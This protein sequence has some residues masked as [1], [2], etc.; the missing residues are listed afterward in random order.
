MSNFDFDLFVI[1][2]GSGGVRAARKAAGEGV[3]V[4]IAEEKE[5]GGTCV[6][7]GCVPKKLMVYAA[8][9]PQQVKNAQGFGWNASVGEFDWA[10]FIQ[11]K[12]TEILRLNGIYE[13]LLDNTGVTLFKAKA[14]LI[15][16][17]TLQVGDKIIT[18]KRILI[19]VGGKPFVP[20]FNGKELCITSD[21]VFFLQ[22]QPKQILVVG[23][24]YIAV[25]FA[26]IFKGMGSKVD[27]LC[28]K[29]RVL[30][31]FDD[32]TVEFLMGQMQEQG[33]DIMFENCIQKIET[34]G[35]KKQVLFK[36]G[37]SRSYDQ[38]LLAT[39][40]TSAVDNLGLKDMGIE[41]NK[42]NAIVV[43]NNYQTNIKD[44]YAIGDVI[45]KV[46]LTP[47]AIKEAMG[48]IAYWYKG[49]DS[50]QIDYADIPT[51]V[52]C[53]PNIGTVGLTQAQA[54]QDFDVQVYE[55]NFRPMSN[56]ISGDTSRMYMKLIVE[57]SSQKVL[58]WHMCGQ[59]AGEM[60]QGFAVAIKM[61]ATKHDF[62]AVIGIHPTAAEEWV[63]LN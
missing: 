29:N 49:A 39:G 14:K 2:A 63:T 25:E 20:D 10:A 30:N 36:D 7:V 45:G 24:G 5:L 22:E 55:S 38:I 15:K 56:T 60:L 27:V 21:D 28:R 33:I 12:N 9:Y 3:K 17:N 61:G 6:N 59:D 41:L 54:E 4:G 8:S 18:A 43:D 16:A 1:G 31:G 50:A 34:V 57:K 46:Q 35:N 40:R 52:F 42:T 58:G 47:V 23:G 13:N 44:V 48:L 19:A 62:D 32:S 51:A 53:Q 26:G 37:Q 11:K